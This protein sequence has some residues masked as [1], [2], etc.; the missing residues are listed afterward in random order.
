MRCHIVL[1]AAPWSVMGCALRATHEPVSKREY[2]GADTPSVP[3]TLVAVDRKIDAAGDVDVSGRT[4]GVVA[5]TD[6]TGALYSK[7]RAWLDDL[8]RSDE[9]PPAK[10]RGF[11]RMAARE[12][13]TIGP[14]LIRL[15]DEFNG[16]QRVLEG[17]LEVDRQHGTR[18]YAQLLLTESIRDSV[19]ASAAA[20]ASYYRN[21]FV[22][23]GLI[24]ACSEQPDLRG[25][26]VGTGDTILQ[27][28]S[29]NGTEE[30][31]SWAKEMRRRWAS[32]VNKACE[33]PTPENGD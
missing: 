4:P 18:H 22:L 33:A 26:A 17:L 29:E 32:C 21:R 24:A 20:Q 3:P 23:E 25:R 15:A 5:T 28:M 8:D 1:L 7:A 27:W 31:R 9:T 2:P 30:G 16:D 11:A 6:R 19:R 13:P 10:A 14:V 12:G